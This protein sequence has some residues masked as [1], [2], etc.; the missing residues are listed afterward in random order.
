MITRYSGIFLAI[1]MGVASFGFQKVLPLVDMHIAQLYFWVFL[2]FAIIGGGRFSL[3]YALTRLW[4]SSP[5]KQILTGAIAVV[6]LLGTGLIL[7]N[8]PQE[9]EAAD[10][11]EDAVVEGS[12]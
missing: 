9:P 10:T 11:V 4:K 3:D 12:D 7:E 2:F 5:W 6:I 8:R 1:I